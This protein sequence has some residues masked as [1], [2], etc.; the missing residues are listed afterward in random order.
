V[1]GPKLILPGLFR[2]YA[3]H[4]AATHLKKVFA[5]RRLV[6]VTADEIE[7]Y[8]HDRLRQRV[9]FKTSSGY[10]ERGKLKPTTGVLHPNFKC[11]AFGP[12]S[13]G[14]C[15]SLICRPRV[16]SR[17][18]IKPAGY[19]HSQLLA[20]SQFPRLRARQ[21]R[22]HAFIRARSTSGGSALTCRT[23]SAIRFSR[24][25]ELKTSFWHQ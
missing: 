8:L 3:S 19:S 22:S 18:G 17:P 10:V 6:D 12:R 24:F 23:E 9:R 21:Y 25:W 1:A 4:R 11:R 15:C 14:P 16:A 7:H 20:S 2:T 5:T 13:F